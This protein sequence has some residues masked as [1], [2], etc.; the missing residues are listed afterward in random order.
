MQLFWWFMLIFSLLIPT[1]MVVFGVVFMHKTPKKINTIF[2]YRTKRS[3][4]D[5]KSWV[6][7]HHS[8]GRS[9]AQRG[10]IIS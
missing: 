9:R 4:K 1:V 2:G 7:A 3:M 6:Y 8:F 5:E 10:P